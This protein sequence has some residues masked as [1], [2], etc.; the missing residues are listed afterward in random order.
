MP[1]SL[2]SRLLI[3]AGVVLA[4]FIGIAGFVLDHGFRQSASASAQERLK[5]QIF[6]LLGLA[7]LD[8]P[9]R[10]LG[11]DALPD[12]ALS[13]P[14]SGHYL[15]IYNGQGDVIWRSRSMLGLGIQWPGERPAGNFV[16]EEAVS[17]TEERL[18]CLSYLVQWE[19]RGKSKLANFTLQACEGRGAYNAQVRNFQ[20]SMWLWLG[21]LA[22]FLLLIQTLILRWG[23]GPLRQVATELRAIES[24][25]QTGISGEYPRELRALTR[26][27]NALLAA[28]DSHLLRYRNALGDLAHSLKTP[29]AVIRST[30]E[31]NPAAASVASLLREPVEQLDATIKYQLQRAATAGRSTLAPPLE[32]A[33]VLE[34][35]VNSL[36]K[37]YHART[38]TIAGR[39][40]E[41]V[42]FYGDQGDLMEII[43][44]LAD[45]ACKWARSEV[46][47]EIAAVIN[48][49]FRRQPLRIT[50]QDDGPGL[51]HDKAEMVMQRG[52]RLDESVEGQGIGLAMVREIVEVGY[53][54]ELALRSHATGMVAEV[55]L[56][57]D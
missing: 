15:Q 47:I 54:G 32:V 56:R 4:A 26:N 28:R 19:G 39:V 22:A 46:L 36:R 9:N 27:L 6:M 29:L 16:F 2:H 20:R 24:G 57:F 30:L 31:S 48:S 45:N 43:G 51:P 44:N 40:D 34:R 5:G 13:L 21:G 7:D 49:K 12:P 3:V 55:L 25:D 52:A 11:A 23:L 38:L 17:S 33:P 14:E 1:R 37:V 53:N 50:V 42:K 18:L 8:Q 10:P 41:H 35:I